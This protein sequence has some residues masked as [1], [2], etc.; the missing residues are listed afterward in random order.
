MTDNSQ[1][2][3]DRA[4]HLIEIERQDDAI[5]LLAKA[6][7][8]DPDSAYANGL[9]AQA[10]LGIER[11][12]DALKYA[13]KTIEL[14]P[15]DEWGHR[16]RSL[17]LTEMGHHREALK[18]AEESVRIAPYDPAALSTLANAWLSVRKP[19]KAKEVG[20]KLIEAAP[21]WEGS[22][23]TMGNIQLQSGDNYQAERSFREA[24]KINPEFANARN[25]LG[26]AVLRQDTNAPGSMFGFKSN[27]I[28]TPPGSADD[29]F[30]EALRLQPENEH[31][32]E[33]FKNQ[34]SYLTAIIPVFAF[35]PF[36]MITFV[37]L[38]LGTLISMGITIY[39]SIRACNDVRRKRAELS[40]EMLEFVK[41]VS[42]FGDGGI[43]D[44][45]GNTLWGCIVKT[46]KPHALALASLAVFVAGSSIG[47]G[48]RL[49]SVLMMIA[50][51]YWLA[52]ESRKPD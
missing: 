37:V 47:T 45:I 1:N 38:P 42:V 3:I 36:M 6:L 14:E 46:W 12:E 49:I 4:E 5:P 26:V 13:E 29:H 27:S 10:L 24:L 33:N 48:G 8:L 21:Y 19:K 50:A 52:H 2:L 18:S 43:L 17:V 51:F 41:N 31:A 7:G 28:I 34:Y 22:H 35:I 23:F 11:P 9:M 32:A 25:N 39:W 16:I 44:T 40:P 30:Q 15:E 20:E